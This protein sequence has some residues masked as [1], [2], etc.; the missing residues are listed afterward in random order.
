MIPLCILA[1]FLSE[2]NMEILLSESIEEWELRCISFSI[3]IIGFLLYS[4]V[5]KVTRNIANT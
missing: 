2:A 1:Y 3:L 5:K 4:V